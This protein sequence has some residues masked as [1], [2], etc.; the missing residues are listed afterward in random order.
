MPHGN[1]YVD[2]IRYYFVILTVVINFATLIITNLHK[3]QRTT[4]APDPQCD[5]FYSFDMDVSILW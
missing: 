3:K 5:W 1:V 2:E 4:D